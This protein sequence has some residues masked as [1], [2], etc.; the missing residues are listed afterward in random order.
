[1]ITYNIRISD[2]TK[3]RLGHLRES[4]FYPNSAIDIGA[5]VG[6]WYS[7]F[8]Q[9]FPE[10]EVLSVEGNPKCE[11]DLSK[12]NS[13]YLISLLGKE[14]KSEK[15]YLSLEDEK[16]S[17]AS[18]Y[19]ETTFYYD[20]YNTVEL[21]M[22]TLDSLNREFDFIKMDVQGAELDVVAGGAKTVLNSSVLQLELSVLKYNQGAPLIGEI[23]SRLHD[24]DFEVYDIV[25]YCYWRER[26]NQIDLL[27]INKHK[28]GHLLKI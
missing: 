20:E 17:G 6:Q 23:I 7:K 28:L 21:P 9:V 3:D 13:N 12:V 1:M 19:K 18:I 22:I 2:Y 27:F 14:N 16:C 25:S 15:L 26:L 24:L 4:G 5:N 10:T 11:E 8:N